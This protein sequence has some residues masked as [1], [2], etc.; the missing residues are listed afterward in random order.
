[1]PWRLQMRTAEISR[2][3]KET[4]IQVRLTLDGTG[5][6][7]IATG[8]PFFDHMLES[9]AKHGGFD[10]ECTARGDLQVDTHHTIE[11]VGI[12]IGEAVK[13]A[14]GDG[15]GIRRFSHALVPMDEALATIAMDYSGRPYL[16]FQGCFSQ[17]TIGGIEPDII[18][19]FFTSL[20]TKAGLNAHILFH[21]RND[22]HQCE[23]VFKAFGIA[24]FQALSLIE[25]KSEIPS[26]KGIL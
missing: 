24:L 7:T 9:M 4:E 18:E 14:V 12:V 19:H 22:H 17:R 15:R 8:V 26:T 2:R 25:G 20:C 13:K 16:V 5:K 21:G 6:T 3:T 23:V 10:L 1:M 11:D